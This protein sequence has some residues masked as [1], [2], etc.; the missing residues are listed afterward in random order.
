MSVAKHGISKLCDL[1]G[2]MKPLFWVKGK[3]LLIFSGLANPLN[4]EKTVIS[5]APAYIERLDFKDHHNF[6]PKDIALIRKKLKKWMLIIYL[7]QKKI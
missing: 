7:Q 3:R 6:K 5:L 4:F 1:K 2:N